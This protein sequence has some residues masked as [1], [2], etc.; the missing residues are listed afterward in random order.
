MFFLE[1]IKNSPSKA[2]LAAELFFL[3]FVLPV[4]LAIRTKPIIKL[5][6]VLLGLTYVLAVGISK[7]SFR[8]LKPPQPSIR[9]IIRVTGLSI[10][11]FILGYF[12]M[13]T[14]RPNELLNLMK[15]KP[16]LWVQILFIYAFISVFAQELLYRRFFFNRYFKLIQ[17]K[18][19]LFFI[20]VI[21][22]SLCHLFLHTTWVLVVTAVGGAL[23]AYTYTKEKSLFWTCVEHALYGNIL[24]TI[25]IG[26]ELAFPS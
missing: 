10:L 5:I 24:F 7:K 4:L 15:H 17:N 13:S 25:G 2:V 9:Y 22:F 12:I 11:L 20:N 18:N 19:L 3:F 16:I 23:F 14:N 6:F 26:A 21:C 8:K 1:K